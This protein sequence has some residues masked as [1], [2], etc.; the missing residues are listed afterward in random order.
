M[1]THKDLDVWKYSGEF[2]STVYTLTKGFPRD[3]VYGLISQIRRS[4]VSI[5]SNIAEG[6]ARKG[7]KEFIHFLYIALGS[8]AELETQLLLASDLGY[9]SNIND[10]EI[11]IGRIRSMLLGLVNYLEIR[12]EH[13]KRKKDDVRK[14]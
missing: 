3:E 5:P 6:S 11:S 2:V 10:Y 1:K 14:T 7:D 13:D 12:V 8:T 9:L 4:A